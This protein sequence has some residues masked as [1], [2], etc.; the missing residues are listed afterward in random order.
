MCKCIE[1]LQKDLAHYNTKI[2]EVHFFNGKPPRI[3]LTTYQIEKGRG[4]QKAVRFIA[5]YCPLC[6][7]KYPDKP[8]AK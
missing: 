8:E 1:Q 2:G 3:E 6:G 7:E 4:K 5:L